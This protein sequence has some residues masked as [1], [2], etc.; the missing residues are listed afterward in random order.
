[1][2]IPHIE[3]RRQSPPAESQDSADFGRS[4]L[5]PAEDSSFGTESEPGA[6]ICCAPL[7]DSG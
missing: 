6:E 2:A 7:S 3:L 5:D 4:V 1:M